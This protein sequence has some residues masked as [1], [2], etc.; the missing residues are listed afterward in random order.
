MYSTG[1]HLEIFVGK[2]EGAAAKGSRGSA[3]EAVKRVV[4]F[5]NGHLPRAKLLERH[6]ARFVFWI[7][8][9]H[10]SPPDTIRLSPD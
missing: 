10:L 6:G 4:S 2:G 1:Y 7:R 3:S 5:V 9:D 8:R